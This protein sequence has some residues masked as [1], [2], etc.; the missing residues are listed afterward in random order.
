VAPA[1]GAP[2]APAKKGWKKVVRPEESADEAA[3]VID[4]TEPEPVEM[5]TDDVVETPVAE[6]PPAD[7]DEPEASA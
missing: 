3:P 2:A 5:A 7:T 4:T 1:A 6:I